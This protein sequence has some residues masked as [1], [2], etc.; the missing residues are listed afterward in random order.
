MNRYLRDKEREMRRKPI[1][2]DMTMREDMRSRDMRRG[3]MSGYDRTMGY[4]NYGYDR[5][6]YGNGT[7]EYRGQGEYRGNRDYYGSDYRG[8]D[9]HGSEMPTYEEYIEELKKWIKRLEKK[10]RFNMSC[11]QVIASARNMGAEFKEYSKEEFYAKYLMEITDHTK[12][13][14]DPMIYIQRTIDFFDDDDIRVSPSE[15]MFIY[16]YYIVLGKPIDE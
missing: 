15:K 12:D 1:N 13:G 16:F 9:Y 6:G 5:M 3:D 11:E 7:Y 2:T 8:Y 14:N 4:D 10:A